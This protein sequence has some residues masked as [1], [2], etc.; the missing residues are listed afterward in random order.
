MAIVT[1]HSSFTRRHKW[2]FTMF[3]ITATSIQKSGCNAVRDVSLDKEHSVAKQDITITDYY[4]TQVL[5]V[6][7]GI[8]MYVVSYLTTILILVC[9]C[10]QDCVLGVGAPVWFFQ[11]FPRKSPI[12]LY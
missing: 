5:K 11:F 3:T 8:R 7:C 10:G 12:L 2:P 1:N 9:V 4:D 6:L